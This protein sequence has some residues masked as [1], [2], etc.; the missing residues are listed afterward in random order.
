MLLRTL[1][2]LN[3]N[4][5]LLFLLSYLAVQ[6]VIIAMD[7]GLGKKNTNVLIVDIGHCQNTLWYIDEESAPSWV[8]YTIEKVRPFYVN[9]NFNHQI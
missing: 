9:I 5:Y 8:N 6:S 7:M 4:L 2:H 1:V 3:R